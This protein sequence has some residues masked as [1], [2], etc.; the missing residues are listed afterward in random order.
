MKIT[1]KKIALFF[2]T[3]IL[4]GSLVSAGDCSITNLGACISEKI[5][6]FFLNLINAPLQPVLDL[7]YK[8]LTQ[9]VNISLFSEV[10][11]IIV[12]ILSLF[13]G[14]LLVYVGFKLML[15]GHSPE[16][17]EKAKSNL[18]NIVIMMVL[19]QSSFFLYS[20]A[21]EI[22]ASLTVSIFNMIEKDF[23]LLTIDN[24]SNI[25]L[26]FVFTAPYLIS[27]VITL[28]LLVLRYIC[29][30]AGVVLFAIGIFFYFI[31]PL[32]HYGRLAI[33]SLLVLISLPFFYSIIFLTSS[34]LLDLAFFQDI[35]ILVMLGAFNL[36]NI[37]TL[38]LL[39]FVLI[40][41]ASKITGPAAKVVSIVK[42]V[43]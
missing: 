42:A 33:N 14:L 30:S 37:S 28:T 35:K 15:S 8:L 3:I 39:L 4:A 36:V 10:W 32:N 7:N 22:S 1:K 24:L 26:Q 38:I 18:A 13:Y 17:R 43:S 29:V 31:E 25:G 9:A 23:F 34:M 6:E 2:V 41:A 20:L 11:S 21:I 12:Y 5:F 16:Q 19:V 40:K 27:L